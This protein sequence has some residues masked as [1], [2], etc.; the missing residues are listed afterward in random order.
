MWFLADVP[1]EM[2]GGAA[3]LAPE[4]TKV[5]TVIGSLDFSKGLAVDM[6]AGFG[7]AEDAKAVADAAQKQFD[8]VKG[9]AALIGMSAAAESVKIEAAGSD[10][11][12][13][14]SASMEE[15]TALQKMGS[16]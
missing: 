10:V 3:M 2:A 7:S 6:V 15:I 5:K 8:E 12:V 1:S 11:K 13:A 9:M 4:A 16:E 14:A